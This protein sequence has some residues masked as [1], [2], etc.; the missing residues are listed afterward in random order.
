MVVH[1]TGTE[2]FSAHLQVV[3]PGMAFG[4]SSRIGA[5]RAMYPIT[6]EYS[7]KLLSQMTCMENHLRFNLLLFFFYR[8]SNLDA[9]EQE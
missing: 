3:S 2:E 6:T 5:E 8:A 1:T 9:R 7:L 4:Q